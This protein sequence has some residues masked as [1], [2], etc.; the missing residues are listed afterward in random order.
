MSTKVFFYFNF[1][2]TFDLLLTKYQAYKHKMYTFR[3]DL[4][5]ECPSSPPDYCVCTLDN[6]VRGRGPSFNLHPVITV[7]CSYRGLK[8]LPKILPHNTTT[9]LVQGNQVIMLYLKFFWAFLHAL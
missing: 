8:M 9:L 2:I 6:V 4:E 3:Q 7:D 5:K 1:I